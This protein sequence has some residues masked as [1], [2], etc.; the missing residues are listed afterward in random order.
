MIDKSFQALIYSLCV[1]A[2]LVLFF[3]RAP[4]PETAPNLTAVEIL[5]N[6]ENSQRIVIDDQTP[7]SEAIEEKLKEQA[8]NLSRVTRRVKEQQVARPQ[9]PTPPRVS[10]SDL[11]PKSSLKIAQQNQNSGQQQ[12][13]PGSINDQIDSGEIQLPGLPATGPQGQMEDSFSKSVVIG[14][15]TQGEWIPG[16][17]EGSF[18]ALNTDQFTYYTFFARVKDAVRFRWVQRVR[19]FSQQASP[20]EIIALSRI[21]SPTKIEITLSNK[22]DVLKISTLQTSGSAE[23]DAAASNAFWAASPLNNPPAEMVEEDGMIRLYYSFHVIWQP[24][25]MVKGQ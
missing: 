5:Y 22:G 11:T 25:Y 19:N 21:P 2:L 6:N 23:L 16:V 20:Q 24:H 3:W 7:D 15:T 18:T 4:T 9:E 17:K 12:T 13:S 8:E 1:H 10:L 14:G